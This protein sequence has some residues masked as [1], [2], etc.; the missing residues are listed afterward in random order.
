[1]EV[2]DM[3]D[4]LPIGERVN[5]AFSNLRESLGKY[6]ESLSGASVKIKLDADAIKYQLRL[7]LWRI[8]GKPIS[9]PYPN[10]MRMP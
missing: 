8:H 5:E 4:F 6:A 9:V 3:T 10:V 7:V 1:M 2:V